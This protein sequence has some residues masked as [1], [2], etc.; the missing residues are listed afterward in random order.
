MSKD[1]GRGPSG[2]RLSST[3]EPLSAQGLGSTGFDPARYAILGRAVSDKRATSVSYCY[4]RDHIEDTLRAVTPYRTAV[5]FTVVPREFVETGKDWFERTI[6]KAADLPW[7]SR[8][9]LLPSKREGG[10]Q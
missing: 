10:G 4:H 5:E 2:N 9:N 6:A 1:S 8:R 3:T 7:V